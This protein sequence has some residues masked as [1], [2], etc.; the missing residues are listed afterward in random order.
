MESAIA[1]RSNEILLTDGIIKCILLGTEHRGFRLKVFGSKHLYFGCAS[2]CRGC[3]IIALPAAMG[4]VSGI[5]YEAQSRS[6]P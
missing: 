1:T 6:A 5:T 2:V 4:G 3:G